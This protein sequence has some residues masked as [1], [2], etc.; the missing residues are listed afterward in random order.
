[1]L[2]RWCILLAMLALA[3]GTA[4]TASS[5]SASTTAGRFSPGGP[6]HLVG[7]A[8]SHARGISNEAESTNWS[9]YAATTGTYTSVSASW[10]QPAGKCTSGDQYAAFWVGLDGYSS[11]SVEQTG[12]EVDCAGRTAQYYAWYEMYPGPSENYPNTVRAGDHFNASVTYEG[13]NKFSL[14]IADTTQGWS[15]TTVASLAGAARSSAEVI[16]E[17]PCCTNSGGILPLTDFGTVNITGSEA[18]GSA[19]GN[20]GGVTEI[21]MIDN[22]GRDKDTVTSLSGGENFSATWVRS[23]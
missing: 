16:V 23:N 21:I 13:S 14:Y 3:T 7:A 19:L 4:L 18:N 20:A 1:M 11:S 5:A 9:G 15:H 8:S 2:R 22:E 10:T 6:I 12:S 17:A